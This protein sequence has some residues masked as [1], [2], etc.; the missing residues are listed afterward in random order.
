MKAVGML[1][2]VLVILGGVSGLGIAAGLG[3]AAVLAGLVALF[4]FI[5]A[6]GGPLRADLRLLA[7][8]APAMILGVAG[9][10]LLA[11]VSEAAAIALLCAVVFAAGLLPALGTRYVTVGLG[12][13]MSAVFGYGFRM[14][15]SANAAQII[16]APA[17]AVG[18]VLVLRL[19]LGLRDPGKPTREALAD[20]LAGEGSSASDAARL[21][22]ADRPV[23]WTAR[24]F[25][26]TLRYR[27]ARGLLTARRRALDETQRDAVDRILAGAA[28]TAEQIAGAIRPRSA[29]DSPQE[30]E[31]ID[32]DV[33]LPGETAKVVDGLWSALEVAT[34]AAH[35]RD[36]ST[37]D[38]PAK[39]RRTV[40]RTE[41]EG[42]LSWRSAQLRHA[43]RC[44]LGMAVALVVAAQRPGDPL[45]VSFLMATFAIMQPEWRDSLAKGRQRIGGTVAGAVVLALL[46]WLLPPSALMPA[47]LLAALAGFPFLKTRPVV[48][49]ASMVVLSVGL[50][51]ERGHLDPGGLLAE[52][53][54]LILLAVAIGLLF[55]FA[56][57]P[58][59]RKPPPAERFATAV[60]AVS[61]LFAEAAAAIRAGSPDPRALATRFR[62]AARTAQDLVTG[63]PGAV[64]LTPAQRD[65]V[66]ETDESLRGLTAAAVAM[67]L[68]P[69]PVLADA[70]ESVAREEE[71]VFETAKLGDEERLVL[72]TM[73]ADVL[74]L[75]RAE[76]VLS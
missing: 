3:S 76:A 35:E 57:V 72:D 14:T 10:R 43:V 44:A 50:N 37:V 56:A 20:A 8:F 45:T 39:L 29:M 69:S 58:G 71:P 1:V 26:A 63:E 13:G 55:G 46:A 23:T 16:A 2:P 73:R 28:E 60:S 66:D 31:R 53:A 17:L 6:F 22:L 74:R 32:A 33:E 36:T 75:R 4:C 67:L 11:G 30:I 41:L 9:P 49:T 15:G 48:F 42:A 19:L 59:V 38:V 61:A 68:N 40:L 24:V 51:A 54:L 62:T 25:G 52:Y 65:T 64:P 34:A 7:V 5:A 12:L 21:W 47:G 27:T 18:A 70:A